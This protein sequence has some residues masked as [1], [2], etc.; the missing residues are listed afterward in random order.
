[1]IHP[2]IRQIEPIDLEF[3]SLKA[4]FPRAESRIVFVAAVK[5]CAAGVIPIHI[6]N[7]ETIACCRPLCIVLMLD[8]WLF[9]FK[10]A[11]SL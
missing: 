6:L 3:H 8:D 5:G 11:I 1:L 4:V 9:V 7:V 2:A 10:V